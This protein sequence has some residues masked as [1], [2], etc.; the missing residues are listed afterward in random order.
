MPTGFPFHPVLPRQRANDS[1]VRA[2][3]T[4]SP[5]RSASENASNGHGDDENMEM[6]F[7]QNPLADNDYTFAKMNGRLC[8]FPFPEHTLM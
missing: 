1:I 7:L 6:P 5:G 3:T 8:K 4:H 2:P